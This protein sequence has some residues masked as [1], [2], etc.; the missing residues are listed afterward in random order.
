MHGL[1][2][3]RFSHLSG[4]FFL[5]GHVTGMQL[6]PFCVAAKGMQ[7]HQVMCSHDVML[8]YRH[9]MDVKP[10]SGGLSTEEKRIFMDMVTALDLIDT[11]SSLVLVL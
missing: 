9:A 11:A 3:L 6:S 1:A 8:L 4:C 5:C 10:R 2:E 7:P